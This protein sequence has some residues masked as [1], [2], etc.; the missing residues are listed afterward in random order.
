MTAKGEHLKELGVVFSESEDADELEGRHFLDF[1]SN[2]NK[3]KTPIKEELYE[4]TKIEGRANESIDLRTSL[5][6]AVKNRI[7]MPELR[8]IVIKPAS[9]E[10][11]ETISAPPRPS[12]MKPIFK[13]QPS[14]IESESLPPLPPKRV[15]KNP[16]K[17]L[18]AIPEKD[19]T[20]A[21]IRKFLPRIG[22]SKKN[23]TECNISRRSSIASAHFNI[24]NRMSESDM[25]LTDSLTEAEHYALYTSV[26]P[27]ATDSEFDENSCYYSPVEAESVK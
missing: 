12:S 1:V 25:S 15:K 14:L 7:K 21:M 13:S 23:K 22:R 16:S 10:H 18:P 27:R 2:V 26:A 20:F 6:M 17:C 8:K 19:T 4:E 3:L 5:Q 24:D 11:Y 9:V